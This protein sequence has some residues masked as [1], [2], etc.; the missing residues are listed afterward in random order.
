MNCYSSL[1]IGDSIFV[2]SLN[3]KTIEMKTNEKLAWR[4]MK[5]DLDHKGR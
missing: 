4:S 5:Q 3:I 1:A 2:S